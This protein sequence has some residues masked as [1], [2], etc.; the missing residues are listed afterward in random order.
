MPQ[1]AQGE[2]VVRQGGNG[3]APANQPAPWGVEG[4]VLAAPGRVSDKHTYSQFQLGGPDEVT[5]ADIVQAQQAARMRNPHAGRNQLSSLVMS[6]E[7]VENRPTPRGNPA[8]AARSSIEITDRLPP[9][10]ARQPPEGFFY[11]AHGN[12]QAHRAH[13]PKPS[14]ISNALF[15]GQ[16][17]SPGMYAEP[18]QLGRAHVDAR[19]QKTRVDALVF[20]SH[21]GGP[22]AESELESKPEGRRHILGRSSH[23]ASEMRWAEHGAAEE[24]LKGGGPP[25][26]QPMEPM[27]AGYDYGHAP[28][29]Y[30]YAPPDYGYA[31]PPPAYK[32]PADGFRPL[33]D[34]S[35]LPAAP[36][37][38]VSPISAYQVPPSEQP[39]SDCF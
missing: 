4:D 23:I 21:H 13:G 15:G 6:D 31:P 10:A 9:D 14:Q 17:D 20:N 7:P 38:R 35:R 5:R 11:N 28:P 19:A 32:A 1:W 36:P 37:P 18:S 16:Q 30:G 22:V 39:H 26:Y 2:M 33:I 34:Y 12:L 25:P 24:Y 27:G 8:R 29:D 3:Y